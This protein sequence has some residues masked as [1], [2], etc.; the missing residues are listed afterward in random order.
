M[1]RFIMKDYSTEFYDLE[2]K[3]KAQ[4]DSYTLWEKLRQ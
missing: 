3:Y 4:V 2:N 1:A